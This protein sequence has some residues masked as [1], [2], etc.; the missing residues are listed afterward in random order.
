VHSCAASDF[1]DVTLRSLSAARR[2]RCGT[3]Q[4]SRKRVMALFGAWRFWFVATIA[5]Q[6]HIVVCRQ[7]RH[8][9]T[10]SVLSQKRVAATLKSKGHQHEIIR[11]S[12]PLT[13]SSTDNGA[14]TAFLMKLKAVQASLFNSDTEV[15]M[16]DEN[17]SGSGDE[18]LKSQTLNQKH[19]ATYFG[20]VVI[21]ESSPPQVLRVMFDTGSS[22]FWVPSVNC[23]SKTSPARFGFPL[24]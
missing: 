8:T 18:A 1:I 3:S 22:E 5:L 20:E 23:K 16:I 19:L 4:L 24:N 11:L 7:L 17:D 15:S 2:C 9:D 12:V 10:Q 6:C 13:R 21:G 14:H